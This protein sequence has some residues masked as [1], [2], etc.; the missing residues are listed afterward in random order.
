MVLDPQ[1]LMRFCHLLVVFFSSLT[2]AFSQPIIRVTPSGAGDHSGSSWANA[3]PGTALAG[4]IATATTGTQFWIGAGVYKPT[5]TTDRTASFSIASGVSVYGGFWGTET[6]FDERT[7]YADL[8]TLSGDIGV[9]GY[10]GD[11]STHVVSV[12]NS[13]QLITL[14]RLTIYGG[15]RAPY[16]YSSSGAGLYIESGRNALSIFINNCRFVDNNIEGSLVGGGAI[17]AITKNNSQSTIRIR[18][19]Y[20]ATNSAESGGAFASV[21]QSGSAKINLDECLFSDN[22]ATYGGAVYVDPGSDLLDSLTINNCQFLSNKATI[23]G[24]AISTASNQCRIEYSLFRYN[25]AGGDGG[26]INA[27]MSHSTYNN[28]LFAN[29]IAARGGVIY[30]KSGD[31]ETS[32][33]FTNCNLVSN[34]AYISG[35]AFYNLMTDENIMYANMLRTNHTLLKN[36]IVW[37]NTAPDSPMFK[38]QTI[39]LSVGAD[40]S[41]YFYANYS[42][43][44]ELTTLTMQGT[45]NMISDPSFINPASGN[46]RLLANSPAI[47][48][49]DPNTLDLL[50][51]DLAGQPRVQNG[52]VDM[53]AYEST[54]LPAPCVPIS[55]V[56]K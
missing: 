31:K 46:Y 53:G 45:G 54:C 50:P 9:V 48:T 28:C 41:N 35:G 29:N 16:D 22:S 11:N 3:L 8:A 37:N 39:H 1:P 40:I 33:L 34:S 12:I 5:T 24:G 7:P 4:S 14:D 44:Q 49:G 42:D 18:G 17:G 15:H 10:S 21:T 55:A 23:L 13:A 27:S 32:L 20:F 52:R 2:F 26:A 38:K 36:C 47:N 30:S 6:T 43:L 19:S 56:R 25:S 51:T